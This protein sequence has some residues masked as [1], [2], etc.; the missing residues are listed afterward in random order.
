MGAASAAFLQVVVAAGALA[1]HAGLRGQVEH[2]PQRAAVAAG[3]VQIP[4]AAAGVVGDRDQAGRGGAMAGA[5]NAARSPAV[6][7]RVAPRI[8]AWT[9]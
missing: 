9:G 8:G 7:S 2:M 1:H 5:G 6:T 4:G 3:L